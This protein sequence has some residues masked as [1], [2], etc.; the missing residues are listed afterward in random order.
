M[1][2]FYKRL[3]RITEYYL[4]PLNQEQIEAIVVNYVNGQSKVIEAV[5]GVARCHPQ[6]KL[7]K[8]IG[9]E[10]A[11]KRAKKTKL[12]IQDVH[13]NEHRVAITTD[14]VVIIMFKD[15][16]KVIVK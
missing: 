11:Q 6:D 1:I 5:Y 10:E 9:K 7:D 15:S 2:T 13:V 3:N 14:R 12:I 8:K 16:G 4:L